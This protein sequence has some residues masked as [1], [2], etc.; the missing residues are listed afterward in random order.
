ML[1]GHEEGSTAV[2]VSERILVPKRTDCARRSLTGSDCGHELAGSSLPGRP[3]LSLPLLSPSL[4][5]LLLGRP[6]G[7][8]G[9]AEE[10]L[11]N[12]A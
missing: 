6:A 11:R 5:S 12:N 8:W 3:L 1:K 2:T 9:G 7:G 10:I 4:T